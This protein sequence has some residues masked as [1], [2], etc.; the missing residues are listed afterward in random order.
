[1]LRDGAVELGEV[2]HGLRLSPEYVDEIRAMLA[3]DPR[4]ALVGL[5]MAVR[6]DGKVSAGRYRHRLAKIATPEARRFSVDF[7]ASDIP[8]PARHV[9]NGWQKTAPRRSVVLAWE[10]ILCERRCAPASAR[11][12]A[13]GRATT[14]AA[15]R[16]SSGAGRRSRRSGRPSIAACADRC[17]PRRPIAAVE[18]LRQSHGP[19]ASPRY[20]RRSGAFRSGRCAPGR[21]AARGSIISRG[22]RPFLDWAR[23]ATGDP[24]PVARREALALLARGA[25]DG[26]ARGGRGKLLR[27][28]LGPKCAMPP[29]R[30][31]ASPRSCRG[32]DTRPFAG[33]AARRFSSP[34]IDALGAAIGPSAS[35]SA[36]RRTGIQASLRRS[37]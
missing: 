29:S 16:G 37:R 24:E 14:G 3:S 10:Q 1:M 7:A 30:P 27:R 15:R 25:P 33:R 31:S 34:A 13:R 32:R 18:V 22:T 5:E 26:E 35:R 11:H 9:S 8:S 6:C 20:F 2:E 17:P 4:T 23:R 21:L 12:A 19:D 36:V 28:R